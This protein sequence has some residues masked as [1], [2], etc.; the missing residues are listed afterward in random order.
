MHCIHSAKYLEAIISIDEI[1]R[2]HDFV[3]A[4]HTIHP[5]IR[6]HS[7]GAISC[8]NV[9]LASDSKKQKWNTKSSAEA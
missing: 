3:D 4:S 1:T 2:T 8:R 9:I 7:G 5:N 6:S